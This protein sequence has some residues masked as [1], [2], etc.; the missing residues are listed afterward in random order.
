MLKFLIA[1]VLLF[2]VLMLLAVRTAGAQSSTVPQPVT[3]APPVNPVDQANAEA[4]QWDAVQQAAV[5]QAQAAAN[6]AAAAAAQANAAAQQAQAAAQMEKAARQ[7]AEQ[8]LMNTAVESAHQAELASVEA[9]ALGRDATQ[10]ASLARQQ[11]D[12]ALRN[13]AR[14]KETLASVANQRDAAQRDASHWSAEAT[15]LD[16]DRTALAGALV[17]ERE[18]S[19][20]MMKVAFAALLLLVMVLAYTAVMLWKVARVLKPTARDRMVVVNEQG[21]VRAQI[22]AIG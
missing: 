7:A 18:R 6:Q 19:D 9:V 1:I 5:G 13:V 12:L 8:G 10:S 14:L 2:L 15:R 4:A 11:S 22:E 17:A 3:P 16:K 20:L 21:Q